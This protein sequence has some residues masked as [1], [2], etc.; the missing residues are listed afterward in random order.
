MAAKLTE[1]TNGFDTAIL[2][3]FVKDID[4]YEA[5]MATKQGEY[6]RYCRGQRELINA[7]LDR[8]KDAG[9]P[10]KDLKAVLKARKLERKIEKIR[11]DLEEDD[12]ADTFD[13]IREALGDLNGTPL[14]DAATGKAQEPA[15]DQTA[16]NVTRLQAGVKPLKG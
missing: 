9:I 14:G 6:M 11:E 3:Q 13:M 15:P 5:D 10:K 16:E 1:Q 7:A 8:A 2:T 4:R 12:A